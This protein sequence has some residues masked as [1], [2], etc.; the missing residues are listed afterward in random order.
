MENS[1]TKSEIFTAYNKARAMARR[2]GDA[3]RIERINKALGILL[4]KNYYNGEKSNYSPSINSCSCND[5]KY[6][7]ATRRNY[8]GVC[9]H[10]EAERLL[11]TIYLMRAEHLFIPSKV[12]IVNA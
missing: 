5:M 11:L 6:R 10:V 8:H 12:V 7:H 1:L 9:K 2:D 4:S 3:K